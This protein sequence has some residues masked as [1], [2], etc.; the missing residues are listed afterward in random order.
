M[1]LLT[2]L[3]LFLA[4][5][6]LLGAA[7]GYGVWAWCHRRFDALRLDAPTQAGADLTD[8][9]QWRHRAERAEL[10]LAEVTRRHAD[11][12]RQ[13]QAELERV[14]AEDHRHR[15]AD[16]ATLAAERA[17]VEALGRKLS[18]L[19]GQIAGTD[20]ATGGAAPSNRTSTSRKVEDG[21][22]RLKRPRKGKSDDL[23]LIW[24]VGADLAHRL[25]AL[26]FF[27]FDQIAKWTAEDA[28]WVSNQLGDTTDRIGREKWVEQCQKLATGWRPHN[29]AG[30]RPN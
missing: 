14:T 9:A 22:R 10:Q 8:H 15:E 4:A 11:E 18:E 26:G 17:K 20:P 21:P 12:V 23:K 27:H 2:Q 25:N 30:E 16:A 24:G 6:F 7:L 19:E 5:A 1:Y 3:W 29:E 13:V 28:R